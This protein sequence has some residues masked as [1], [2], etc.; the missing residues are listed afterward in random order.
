L[1][2]YGYAGSDPDAFRTM[3][4]TIEFI[5]SNLHVFKPEKYTL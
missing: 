1:P 2:G 4:E 3:S 5:E